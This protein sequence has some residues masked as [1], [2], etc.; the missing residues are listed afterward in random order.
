MKGS[1]KEYKP[2]RWRIRI[3]HG[4]KLHE[5]VRTKHGDILEGQKQAHKAWAQ[6]TQE[7]EENVFDPVDWGRE[8]PFI[9]HNAFEVFQNSKQCGEE[10]KYYR[11]LNFRTHI[12]PI[13]GQ[14]DMREIKSV[15]VNELHGKLIDKGLSA[16]SQ[17]NIM[18]LLASIFHFHAIPV[19]QFPKIKVQDQEIRWLT[20]EQQESIMAHLD[21]ED[22]PIFRFMQITGCRSGEACSLQREDVEWEQGIIIIR[23]SM[24]HRRRVIPYTK[25]KRIK[26]I[27]ISTFEKWDHILRPKEVTP[28][29][30]SREGQPYWRQR[31]QRAWRAA[32][33]R[34]GISLIHVKNAFRHSLAS[35]EIQKGTPIEAISKMLG[36]S[37]I[38][39]TQERY[40]NLS[41]ERAWGYRSGIIPLKKAEENG[42]K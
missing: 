23:R 19:P 5:I 40:A 18:A 29:I 10:W 22:K 42:K 34:S 15:H 33:E 32:N 2:G 24:G 26:I 41:P 8:K 37:S 31:L 25:N 17:K 14:M 9:L 30:F 39:V 38:K 12:E 20:Q 16:K 36:H 27:P 21:D 13:L 1:C 3:W 35:Q 7:I 4:G 28:F 11:G 6:V